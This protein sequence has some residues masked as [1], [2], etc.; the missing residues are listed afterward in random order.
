MSISSVE[1]GQKVLLP[2][3]SHDFDNNAEP[4]SSTISSSSNEELASAYD[5]KKYQLFGRCHPVIIKMYNLLKEIA[6]MLLVAF[7]YAALTN[8]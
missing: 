8:E 1:K 4:D 5:K 3:E 7:T 6:L 2:T